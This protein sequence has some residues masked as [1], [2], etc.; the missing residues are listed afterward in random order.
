MKENNLRFALLMA[1]NNATSFDTIL[2][3]LIKFVLAYEEN[4]INSQKISTLINENFELEFTLKDIETAINSDNKF[5]IDKIF[6]ELSTTYFLKPAEKDKIRKNQNAVDFSNILKKFKESCSEVKEMPLEKIET[7]LFNYLYLVFNSNINNLSLL[8]KK[9]IR[10]I[11]DLNISLNE[12]RIIERFLEWENDDKNKFVYNLLNSS[13]EYCALSIGNNKL[14]L[15]NLINSKIFILDTNII[16]SSIGINGKESQEAISK[17]IDRCKKFNISLQYTN[18]T[19][20]EA[21]KTIS[22]LCEQL[23]KYLSNSKSILKNE[24]L[25]NQENFSD[26]YMLYQSWVSDD[27]NNRE[28]NFFEFSKKLSDDLTKFLY[29]FTLLE[30]DRDF[31][32]TNYSKIKETEKLFEA[33]KRK[34]GRTIKKQSVA[35]DMI[36]YNFVASKNPTNASVLIDNKYYFITLDNLLNDWAKNYRLGIPQS[37]LPVNLIYTILLRFSERSS[38][39]FKSY[40]KFLLFGIN[41][42]FENSSIIK[43]KNEIL[44]KISLIDEASDYKKLIVIETNRII[45]NKIINKEII[46]NSDVIIDKAYDNLIAELFDENEKKNEKE[47]KILIDSFEKEKEELIKSSTQTGEKLEKERNI[48]INTKRRIKIKKFFI[49]SISV[50]FIVFLIYFIISLVIFCRNNEDSLNFVSFI[51]S[52]IGLSVPLLTGIISLILKC[53]SLNVFDLSYEY[54][55]KKEREKYNKRKE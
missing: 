42:C 27:S 20:N 32:K 10:K 30:I 35:H 1:N 16:L 26:F 37:V 31:L 25:Q 45:E 54:N 53:F 11:D 2:L 47:K 23:E 19:K 52:L 55:E 4:P 3:K 36:V 50:L 24:D 12:K 49:C 43:L 5:A 44:K 33:Y 7:I 40:S 13:Y 28:N 21:Q 38:D 15:E 51:I 48:R 6:N 18:L 39:D 8:C 34:C 41:Y 22:Y 14:P 17:F 29:D 46:E 9:E